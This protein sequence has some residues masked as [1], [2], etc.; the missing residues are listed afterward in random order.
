MKHPVLAIIAG[1]IFLSS[2][3]NIVYLFPL[4][5]E[6]RDGAIRASTND[7]PEQ[8]P[9]YLQAAENVIGY[10]FAL[11]LLCFACSLVLLI[12]LVVKRRPTNVE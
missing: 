4:S 11:I 1:I 8:V 7:V 9:G 5:N 3:A 12:S 2:C 6:I 10:Q